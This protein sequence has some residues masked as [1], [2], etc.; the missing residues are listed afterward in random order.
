MPELA[1]SSEYVDLLA[2]GG[3]SGDESDRFEGRETKEHR[4]FFVVRPAWRSP[5]VTPWLRVID[6]V[7]LDSQFSESGRASR[8]NW[9]RHRLDCCNRVDHMRP[10]VIGLPMNFYDEQ[11]LSH[12][13]QMELEAL[14]MREEISLEHDPSLME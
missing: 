14:G 11:W 6:N 10:A 3:M 12:L 7:Y 8:G 4:K 13:S 1:A 2:A 9:V 5:K